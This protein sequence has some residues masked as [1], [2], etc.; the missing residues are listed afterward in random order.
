MKDVHT[1]LG[2]FGRAV[3]QQGRA[4]PQ[5]SPRARELVQGA[6]EDA[7]PESMS[8]QGATAG[9]ELGISPS[10]LEPKQKELIHIWE[11]VDFSS[12]RGVF[13]IVVF[14][15]YSVIDSEVQI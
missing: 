8:V 6:E 4:R 15:V 10:A 7:S 3:S 1:S 12:E 5:H 9:R 11:H 14:H 2:G 13:L